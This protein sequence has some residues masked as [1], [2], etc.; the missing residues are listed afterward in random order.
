MNEFMV[1]RA[2][3]GLGRLERLRLRHADRILSRVK[4]E[5][6]AVLK[7]CYERLRTWLTTTAPQLEAAGGLLRRLARQTTEHPDETFLQPAS[8]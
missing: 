4:A 5:W 8:G 3:V 1:E 6:W 2:V 7:G